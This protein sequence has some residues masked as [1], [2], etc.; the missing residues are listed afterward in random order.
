MKG[1]VFIAWSG[2]NTLAVEI[3]KLIEQQGYTGVVGGQDGSTNGLFVGDVVLEE[4]NHSNQAIFVVQKKPDGTISHNLTFELG[5]ALAK[6]NSKKIH[7]YYIDINR[8]DE[9][10]PSDLNGIWADHFFSSDTENIAEAVVEKFLAEQKYIIPE[11]KMEVIDS[12]YRIKEVIQNY[13]NA[14]IYSEYELSQYV[15]FFSQAA[16]L[17]GNDNEALDALKNLTKELGNPCKELS[18]SINFGI[19]YIEMIMKIQSRDELLFLKKE[20]FRDLSRELLSIEAEIETW[21][22]DD[23]TQWFSVLLFDTINYSY[24]LYASNPEIST[25]RKEKRL[26]ASIEYA[27]K[28]LVFCDKLLEN[29]KNLYFTE[30][31]KAYMYRNLATA[32]QMLGSDAEL[33]RENLEESFKMRV[34][35]WYHYKKTNSIN[36]RLMESF[37]MEYFLASSERLEYIDDD[38]DLED[39]CDECQEYINK[40]QARNRE[41]SHFVDKI[42]QNIVSFGG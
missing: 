38:D 1:K 21:P 16:Y 25:E 26:K 32:H 7:V 5:Y 2:Q 40:V 14:P 8:N 35:L 36:L 17:F 4:I 12:Y 39:S 41:K 20:D 6:F 28:C 30:L 3:K 18:L 42:K 15:L 37:E 23:F 31:Y 33:I 29:S 22:E 13:R 19:L 9:T 34:K 27:E 24:V 11:N 10:I